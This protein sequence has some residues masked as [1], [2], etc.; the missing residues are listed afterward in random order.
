MLHIKT[1]K[2]KI[3]KVIVSNNEEFSVGDGIHFILRTGDRDMD[4]Y[5][6]IKDIKKDI[7]KINHVEIDGERLYHYT[8]NVKYDQVKNGKIEFADYEYC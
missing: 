5:G 2:P 1:A 4:C 6:I 8:L 7:F 3:K